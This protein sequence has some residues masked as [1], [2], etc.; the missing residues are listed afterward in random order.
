VRFQP[1]RAWRNLLRRNEIETDLDAEV[2]AY[3]ELAVDEKT[4]AGATRAQAER[5]VRA[6]CGGIEQVKQ[7]VR[8]V[9]SGMG[10]ETFCQDVRFGVR[11][12]RRNPVFAV[13]AILTLGIGIGANSAIFS[14]V[15]SVLLRP[16][17]YPQPDRLTVIW[18]DLGNS[19]RAPASTF[20][21]Y[22]MRQRTR[23]FDQIAGIWVTNR[24]LPGKGDAEQGKAAVVTSNFLPLF[25]VRPALGRFFKPEDDLENAPSTIVLSHELWMH[26]F[27]G[28]PRVVGTSVPLGRGSAVVIGVL[29]QNFKLIFPDD[30]SVPAHVDYYE[31][32]P[33]GPWDPNGPGFLH[34]IGRLRDAGRLPAAQAELVSIAG[35]INAL[36][37]RTS[38]ANYRLYVVSLQDDDVRKVRGTLLILFG[39]VGFVLLIG[40]ANVANL[41]IVR[42][43]QRAHE[44]AVRSALGASRPRLIRQFLTET[45]LMV[46]AGGCVAL[47]LGWAAVRAIAPVAPPSFTNLGPARLDLRVLVFTFTVAL[48]T[49]LLF[50]MAPISSI[51]RVH[52]A[53]DL[54]RT[55]RST[56][57]RHGVAAAFLI[58]AEVA[59]AFVLLVGT[60]L[61]ARTFANILRVN[62]GFQA[63]NVFTIRANVPDYNTLREVQRALIALPGVQS[64]S[65]VS[66]LPL[67]DTGNWYD[68]YWKEGAPADQ[69]NTTMADDR[70]VL[71][72]YFSTIGAQLLEGRDF[73]DA[74]DAA[75]QHVAV[76]D[77]LLAR[78]LWPGENPLGKRINISDS[79]KGPYQFER[80]WVV[81]VG[82][83]RHVQCHTLTMT[84][85]P[86]I[87]LPYQL[88]PRPSMSMVM[89]SGEAAGTL[90]AAVRRQITGLNRNVP[91][92]HLEPLSAVVER[93]RAETRFVSVLAGLLSIVGLQLALGGI[94]AVLSN[95]VALR[96]AE[97]G[98]RMAVGAQR[99][100]IM[101]L[102]FAQGFASVTLGI[103]GGVV[104]S[105]FSM[106]LLDR[107]LFEIS[108]ESLVNYGLMTVAILV[109]SAISMTIP[110]IRA[111]RINPV[112][113][114]TSE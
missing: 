71:P 63:E 37:S 30:A 87:Y 113:A 60:G 55:G 91:I 59:L 99:S 39:A 16:L 1:P 97:I 81:V 96:T 108:P 53:Q 47:L 27:G 89:R 79:P 70:S 4:A 6:D 15:N 66:H 10:F 65:T 18:S 110:A 78:Q 42:A 23:E 105:I 56:T 5:R 85:R 102:V 67:D 2:R 50:G 20:E 43:R 9:R 73:A 13:A 17:P 92:T 83:V 90:A 45:L 14:F 46:L 58:A 57:R 94:Y 11:Q 49:S 80:D 32:T 69:Q 114:L 64:V 33:I 7:G 36:T 48:L 52:L 29:P 68:Y 82:V 84:V 24:A 93:A 25:C 3:V 106:P 104:L 86:Q 51:R 34:L 72:G 40:C 31:S 107:L 21:L 62:P 12:L 44:T 35:Q 95:S 8:D 22:Q 61:L 103:A 41:L 74:D 26:K 38:L 19:S 109:L 28:D 101:R 98:I 111:M 100:E 54:K 76:I 88:A 75:H 77:E 112:T